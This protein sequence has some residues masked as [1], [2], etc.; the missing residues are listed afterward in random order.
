MVVNAEAI[1]FVTPEYNHNMSPVQLNAVDWIGKEWKDKP[2]ALIGYGWR[3]GGGQA[4]DAAREALAVNLG[5]KV[6]EIQANLFFTKDIAPD[7]SII[8][9]ATINEKIDQAL[10][11]LQQ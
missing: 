6:S 2:V 4:H 1:V 5:A 7:G 11:S 3:T 10:T 9:E 8:D